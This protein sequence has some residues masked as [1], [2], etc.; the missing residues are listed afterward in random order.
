MEWGP[1]RAVPIRCS[2]PAE[3]T[4]IIITALELAAK[5]ITY[6]IISSALDQFCDLVCF[7][8]IIN[9]PPS[10]HAVRC[11]IGL[12]LAVLHSFF[13]PRMFL[14]LSLILPFT[15]TLD[16]SSTHARSGLTIVDF[17]VSHLTIL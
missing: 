14:N 2:G 9:P 3:T 17:P 15:Y 11:D 13:V 1:L 7:Y 16:S 10:H 6:H 5:S 4:S 8:I 12:L